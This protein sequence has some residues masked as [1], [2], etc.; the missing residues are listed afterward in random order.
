MRHRLVLGALVFSATYGCSPDLVPTAPPAP[1]SL[2]PS[3]ALSAACPGAVAE[4]TTYASKAALLAAWTE[5]TVT[6]N[7]RTNDAGGPITNPSTD[8][9][10][11][12][13][14]LRGATF[15]NVQSY[16]NLVVYTFPKTVLHVDLP[17]NTYAAGT[18]LSAFYGVGGT[19][20]I[21][22]SDGKVFTVP[23]AGGYYPPPA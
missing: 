1:G 5:P 6:I 17:A 16:Y 8:A 15:R 20:T 9:F 22:L 4:V 2:A 12:A 21:T 23:Y 18:E 10:F 14:T 7:F 19:F 13:L 3:S 11:S